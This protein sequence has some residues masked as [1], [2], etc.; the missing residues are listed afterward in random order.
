MKKII[1]LSL[2][3]VF[4]Q[5]VA[6][7]YIWDAEHLAKVKQQMKQPMYAV[8]CRQLMSDADK[9]L[10]AQPVS[11]MQKNKVAVS[12]D[13]HDYLS[14][15]PFYWQEPHGS[16]KEFAYVEHGNRWNPEAFLLDRTRLAAMARKVTVLSQAYAA[17]GDEKY[18]QQATQ[19]L[20]AW[21][22][23]KAT[24]MNPHLRY[25]QVVPGKNQGA[26]R[27]QG[28]IET[29]PFVGMLR[30]MKSL[31]SS[32]SYDTALR[33][34]LIEWFS[35][36]LQWMLTDPMAVKEGAAKNNHATS[37]DVQ[38]LAYSLFVG[39]D[40]TAQRIAHSFATKRIMAQVQ[41]D[42]KQPAELKR[43][44]PYQ[45]SCQNLTYMQDA[46]AIMLEMDEDLVGKA[47]QERVKEGSNFLRRHFSEQN[48]KD[49]WEFIRT[50]MANAWEVFRPVLPGKPESVPLWTQ[51]SLPHT[52]NAEDAVAP[53]VNYYEGAAWYRQLLY[54]HSPYPDGRILL[55]FEGAGQKTEVYVHTEKVGC[56]VGGYD[57]WEVDITD[58]VRR[59]QAEE[60]SLLQFGG[61][62]PIAVR[63]DNSRDVEM[64]PSDMSDFTL[65]GGLYR[66][67]NLVYLPKEHLPARAV[68]VV[69]NRILVSAPLEAWVEVVAPHGKP[70]F[71]G[72][73]PGSITIK[74]PRLWDVDR[75]QLYTV[76]LTLG[77]HTTEQ[78]V[79]FRH[80][81]FREH[82]PFYL[83]GRRLL[84]QGTHRHEDY[85]GVGAA[86]SD[87]QIRQ[88]MKSIKDMGANFIRLGHYQQSD[89][90]LQL[91]DSLGILVWEEIPWCRGG[92]GGEKYRQQARRML[93]NM[94][95]QHRHHPSVIL[96][97]L[98]NENDWPGDFQEFQQDSI[99]SFMRELHE[100]AHRQD[101]TRLTTI[102]R[103]EFCAD[104]VDVYS[105]S[106][107]AGW[108]SKRFT[109]YRQMEEAAIARYPRFIHA[110]WGGDSH[111][112]RHAE[113]NFDIVAGDKTGD[114]SESY[115]VRLFDW[116]LKEQLSMPQLTGAA[117]WTF[118]DFATPLR[119]H[120]PIP[121]VNQKG[122][123]ER[124][125]TPKESYYV[126]QSYWAKKPMLHIYGHSWPIR[127]GEADEKKQVLVYSNQPEVELFVNGVSM[128]KRKRNVSDFPAAGLH[129]DVVLQPG[130]NVIEARSA[131]LYD[132]IEQRYQVESWGK[133]A[134]FD[135]VSSE[136]DAASGE[137]RV[138]VQ[139]VDAAGVPC[140]DAS[141]W[142][143]FGVAGDGTLIADQGTSTGSRRLQTYNGRAIC[144]VQLRGKAVVS[145]CASGVETALIS[146]HK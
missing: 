80:F 89:L 130:A 71:R 26:G 63:C 65:Y 82:G 51:V 54:V 87:E 96:W 22:V 18:A 24:K 42:G 125:G 15:A 101:A 103:C 62:I 59:F 108:Y 72:K 144:R 141:D 29:Y 32:S 33:H 2:I 38:L 117:F 31:E 133:P 91:C 70:V 120:N 94:I 64:I 49:G 9:F 14:Q 53:G 36:Y 136:V 40:A 106:I 146:L 44:L 57:E 116:H 11:V 12:G 41:P 129:W 86:M 105:P 27:P 131:G 137:A 43:P 69:D 45:Y 113:G 39:D 28:I 135:I 52:Y 109:D 104:I 10:A 92:L 13:K 68:T 25:G 58:A 145:A 88:E 48:L 37:Y 74:N 132:K 77:A 23:D 139:L 121:Y 56:H 5:L 111:A 100:L 7:Q 30:Q 85:A 115:I 95:A 34:Q 93:T 21:F 1:L 17:T 55:R 16:G 3:C 76:R 138:E 124:D 20:R 119:P 140:L 4:S 134:R 97:G 73:N 19:Q 47:E 81:E 90:V 112:R 78:K 127:W 6:A 83:N 84:L 126:F 143:E 98:G 99:R 114:W 122:V 142:I 35:A 110:E 66:K 61:L 107:W 118:K 50:D 79:G 123:V 102:R 8:A 46:L 128:G 75:P 67:V 60:T